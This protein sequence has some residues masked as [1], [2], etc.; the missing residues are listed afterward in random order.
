MLIKILMLLRSQYWHLSSEQRP[1]PTTQNSPAPVP[2]AP[3]R[4]NP[5]SKSP[6]SLFKFYTGNKSV[7]FSVKGQVT[8]GALKLD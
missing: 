1:V 6:E 8:D 2:I 4:K 7:F 5:V 3:L